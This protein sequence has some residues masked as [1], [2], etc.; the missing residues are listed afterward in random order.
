[1]R[2]YILGV[3]SW[4]SLTQVC[5]QDLPPDAE[6][7]LSPAS[8]VDAVDAASQA[9]QDDN[10]AKASQ[11]ENPSSEPV[12]AASEQ[13]IGAVDTPS[14]SRQQP[15]PSW[16][17]IARPVASGASVSDGTRINVEGRGFS[18]KPPAGWELDLNHPTL[19]LFMQIPE[20]RGLKYRRTL[21]IA[22]LNSP[23][24]I[25]EISAREFE[26]YLVDNFSKAS[27]SITNYRIRNHAMIELSDKRPAILFYA[28][29]NLDNVPLM[30]AHILA[31]GPDRHYL[32]SYTDVRE[33]FEDDALSAQY[34]SEAWDSMVT[35]EFEGATPVRFAPIQRMGGLAALAFLVLGVIWG[36]RQW[37]ARQTYA[38]YELGD[39]D[40]PTAAGRTEAVSGVSQLEA[41]LPASTLHP[42][43]EHE[44]I[45]KLQAKP[46]PV[47]KPIA[48]EASKPEQ[49][50]TVSH[51]ETSWMLSIN[52]KEIIRM[53][54]SKHPETGL[55]Q[56]SR[57]D[58]EEKAG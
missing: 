10:A 49:S 12:M 50:S 9:D 2:Y 51:A 28:E 24:Y 25:D 18:I 39:G 22:S 48:T 43:S 19:S 5:A 23:R 7:N 47:Q 52:N 57:Y 45:R 27:L 35:L 32:M 4:L 29:M 37:R 20:A 13:T 40:A 15:A 46:K 36:A 1:M 56:L 58:D 42:L 33:H 21:Q 41:S 3:L 34:L 17:E 54:L 53:P 6:E 31:S 30:Q 11:T 26:T 8:P 44:D 14:K 55:S 38:D 16:Q